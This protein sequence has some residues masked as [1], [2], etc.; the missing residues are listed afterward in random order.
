MNQT[1]SLVNFNSVDSA[2]REKLWAELETRIA[3]GVPFPEP[4]LPVTQFNIIRAMFVNAASMGLTKALLGED[5]ASDFNIPGP[6]TLHLPPTLHPSSLQRRIIHHP[7]IDLIPICSVRNTLLSNLGNYDEEE[8][9]GDLYGVCSAANE[10]GLIVWGE[11]WDP[12]AYEVSEQVLRKWDWIWRDCPDLL[13]TTN[14]W[15][16]I[17]GERPLKLP[18][19]GERRVV[20]I[21]D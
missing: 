21:H 12:N 16:R 10:V 9:C 15:R 5:I 14:Y 4:L 17:R 18:K 2:T 3:S 20:E 13:V 6:M 19:L 11:A 8:F 7:W 1:N